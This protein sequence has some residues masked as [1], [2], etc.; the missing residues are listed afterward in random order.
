MSAVADTSNISTVTS[1]AAMA[2]AA[3]CIVAAAGIAVLRAVRNR[4]RPASV[5]LQLPAAALL[6]VALFPP[7][8]GVRGDALTVVTPGAT[9]RQLRDAPTDSPIIALPGASVA[10]QVQAIPD[11][12]TALRAYPAVNALRVIGAGLAA[13]DRP[14]AA[15]L[16]V[17]FDQSPPWGFQEVRSP[18]QT[19]LGRQWIVSGRVASPARRVELRD[20]SGTVVDGIDVDAAGSFRLS[21]PASGAGMVRFELR[22]YA[23]KQDL[24]DRL[25]VPIVIVGGEPLRV[26]VRYGQLNP[27]LKYWRRWA[28]DAGFALAAA[29]SLTQGVFQREGD[30]SLSEAALAQTDLAVVDARGWALLSAAE[31]S[32]LGAAVDR[33]LGLLLRVD[34][35]LPP[36]IAAEWQALGFALSAD[37]TPDG[38]GAASAAVTL[39]RLTGLHDRTPFTIAPIAVDAGTQVLLRADDGRPLAWWRPKGDGRIAL[40]RLTDSYRLVL[41]GE[42]QRYAVLWAG[43]LGFLTRP[44]APPPPAPQLPRVAWVDERAVLCGLGDAAGV[45]KPGD[46]RSVRLIIDRDGC[47]A[48]WPVIDG[49]HRLETRGLESPFYVRAADDGRSWRD[50]INR[51]AT[52]ALSNAHSD[53]T[54]SAPPHPSLR[55]PRPRWPWFAA[56]L[57]V[58]ALIWWQ[59]RRHRLAPAQPGP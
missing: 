3:L 30:A 46:A 35:P 17:T 5:W 45:R 37:A 2:V 38:A 6:Y 56:W 36:A 10:A 58:T 39:D 1:H 22:A 54:G 15:G 9:A 43:P 47:A 7:T 52:E 13:R 34:E 44:R 42:P 12:A 24:V 21:A 49:W 40:W 55:A 4:P 32:A 19:P 51:R 26:L 33:G 53:G 11:L 41:L 20:P 23:A 31:K 8:V 18:A 28:R 48:Y 59:E 25:T 27:E 16:E 57:C 29:V 14:A 50:A